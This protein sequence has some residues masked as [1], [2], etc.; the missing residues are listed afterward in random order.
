MQPF[1]ASRFK[2][3]TRSLRAVRKFSLAVHSF[4]SSVYNFSAAVHSFTSSVYNF[5]SAVQPVHFIRLQFFISR[6]AVHFN[7]F[8]WLVNRFSSVHQPCVLPFERIAVSVRFR[9]R[10]HICFRFIFVFELYPFQNRKHL[11]PEFCNEGTKCLITSLIFVSVSLK[12]EK[13]MS[14]NTVFV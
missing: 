6:S 9:V 5:S 7:R 11:I 4:T 10:G 12:G 2:P 8:T 13:N 3:F 14:Y 1:S